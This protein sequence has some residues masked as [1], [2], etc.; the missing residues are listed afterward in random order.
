M[1]ASSRSSRH[2]AGNQFFLEQRDRGSLK[3]IL[4]CVLGS[5]FASN[6]HVLYVHLSLFAITVARKHNKSTEK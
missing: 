1:K 5:C 6:E 2:I 3:E 4:L